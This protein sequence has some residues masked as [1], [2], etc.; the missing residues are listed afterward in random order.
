MGVFEGFGVFDKTNREELK[1]EKLKE[2]IADKE[3][4]CLSHKYKY[5]GYD[6]ESTMQFKES[7]QN[8]WLDLSYEAKEEFIL[9]MY[10][11][12]HKIVIE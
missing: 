4:P 1:K 10:A 11:K 8:W 5:S 7:A 9:D 12:E 2:D 3:H 6:D